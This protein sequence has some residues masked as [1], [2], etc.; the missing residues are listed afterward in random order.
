MTT[1]GATDLNYRL[2]GPEDAPVLVLSNS[3]GTALEMW[4]DQAPALRERFRVLR[5]D[6][7]GHGESPAPPGPYAIEDLGRD[8]LSLLDHIGVERASFCGLSIGG[9][10][11]MW[12][13]SEAPERVESLVLCC[14]SALLGPKSVWD[15]RIQTATEKG[16]AALVDGV[17][18]R[19]F[20]PAFRSENPE[21][22][23]TMART[24]RG[25][26]PEGYAG[27]CAAIRDMDLRDRLPSIRSPTLVV[28][29]ADDPATP[30]DHGRLIAGAIPGARFEVV[31][32]AAHIANVEQPET[33]TQLILTHLEAT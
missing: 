7:R 33:V 20:T 32:E 10:T 30:P 19:W 14:T 16:M 8:V 28:S 3:L 5:Y 11:G 23:E 13:A 4:D 22:V 24:L 29:G 27:C 25:T 2:E 6:T 9:M 17:I 12:L 18:E 21:A 15:E 1:G 26:D 31:P